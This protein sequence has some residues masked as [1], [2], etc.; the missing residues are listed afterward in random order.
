MEGALAAG[1]P[2]RDAG[3]AGVAV[4]QGAEEVARTVEPLRREVER[5]RASASEAAARLG[6]TLRSVQRWLRDGRLEAVPAGGVRMV[7]WPREAPRG[8]RRVRYHRG[9]S[10]SRAMIAVAALV[11]AVSAARA[12]EKYSNDDLCR[13]I[14][15]TSRVSLQPRDRLFFEK[16]CVCY[17]YD[18]GC[19]EKGGAR[20]K[21]AAEA[22]ARRTQEEREKAA[23]RE[24]AKRSA[25]VAAQKRQA[26]AAKARAARA[27]RAAADCAAQNDEYWTCARS[28]GADCTEKIGELSACCARAGIRDRLECIQAF[29]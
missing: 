14:G 3:R 24:E 29:P 28:P 9:V 12:E 16:N 4:T 26:D 2:A 22:V 13:V 1:A 27:K 19:M 7:R 25:A 10:S 8:A 17:P 5:L 6:V 23:A 18:F 11:L 21:A 20:A 15:E